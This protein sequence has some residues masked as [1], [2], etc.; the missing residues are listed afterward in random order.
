MKPM[1]LLLCFVL[2]A[3]ANP[4]VVEISPDTYVLF[5]DDHAG[6][7]GNAGALRADVIRDA[8]KFA[9]LKGK[10]AVPVSSTYTPMG[11]GPAQWASF[12]YQFRVVN[13]GDEEAVRTSLKKRADHV[14]D[15][16]VKIDINSKPNQPT[17]DIYSELIKINDLLEKGIISKTE[18][19]I[20]KA[21]ILDSNN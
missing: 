13:K 5:R 10:I 12:E 16:N 6:I 8:N 18:F 3:C 20:M 7:F 2:T 9:K 4:S 19:E 11:N 21:K 17:K 1:I 14:V 15:Q